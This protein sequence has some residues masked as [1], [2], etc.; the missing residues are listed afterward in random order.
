[1]GLDLFLTKLKIEEEVAYYRKCNFL[2]PFFEEMSKLRVENCTFLIINK[3]WVE[4][5][6]RR[7]KEVLSLVDQSKLEKDDYKI[8]EEAIEKAQELLPT[9]EGFFFGDTDYDEYYFIKVD[10]VY[11]ECPDILKQFDNLEDSEYIAF[12]IWF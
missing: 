3:E 8:P 12:Y 2:I 1:M 10:S 7:C 5:L 11:K 6:Q 4:E 9:Q